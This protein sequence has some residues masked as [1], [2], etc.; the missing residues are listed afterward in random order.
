MP[1]Y[2]KHNN[3]SSAAV[4]HHIMLTLYLTTYFLIAMQNLQFVKSS[5][6]SLT[7]TD[8]NATSERDW[9]NF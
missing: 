5:V 9:P 3:L 8:M 7:Y 2:F 4:H 6:K 1:A